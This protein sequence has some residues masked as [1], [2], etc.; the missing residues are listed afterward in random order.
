MR[1]YMILFSIFFLMNH[2]AMAQYGDFF[3]YKD[4]ETGLFQDL[5]RNAPGNFKFLPN[6]T[7]FLYKMADTIYYNSI[8]SLKYK[9]LSLQEINM[10]FNKNKID[11]LSVIGQ[12]TILDTDKFLFKTPYRYMILQTSDTAIKEYAFP[13]SAENAS[14]NQ[15]NN[16]IALTIKN[17]LAIIDENGEIN[18]ITNDTNHWITNGHVVHRY[19]FGIEEGYFW[20]PDGK[21]LAF[22]K[23]DQRKITKYPLVETDNDFATVNYIPY[24]MAGQASEIVSVWIYDVASRELTKVKTEGDPEQYYTNITWDNESQNVYIQQLNR[25]QDTMHLISY[26]AVS[27]SAVDTLFTETNKKYVEPQ[28][29]LYFL[30]KGKGDFLYQSRRDGYNHIYYYS[31]TNH[32][33]KQ[34][35]KGDWEVIDLFGVDS[36]DQFLYFRGNREG[37]KQKHIYCYDMKTSETN[38]ITKETGINNAVFSPNFD[39]LIHIYSNYETPLK[40]RLLNKQGN[41]LKEVYSAP[42]S[43]EEYAI[44]PAQYGTFKSADNKWDLNY[45]LIKPLNIEPGQ[46]YPLVFYMYGGP[47]LQLLENSWGGRTWFWQQY[48]AQHGVASFTFDCRGSSNRGFEF[49]SVIHRKNGIPQLEDVN[50]AL[51][52]VKA[53]DYVDTNRLGIHGWS[54]GGFMTVQ[55]MLKNSDDFKVGVAGGPVI[56]WAKYEVMY[57]E[58][59][60]DT[61]QENPDG[62]AETNLNNFADSLKGKLLIIHGAQDPIV[63]WQHSMQ[64]VRSC[65]KSNKQVDY[66]VYPSHEHNVRGKDRE[67]LIEK[68]TEYFL[69]NL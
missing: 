23:N 61:P 14:Y 21:K 32:K 54:F 41:L 20:S 42:N 10:F 69:E 53:L 67:H 25:G 38:V 44:S 52:F 55:L 12:F 43:L 31:R 56:D 9:K 30:K 18:Q 7:V 35:T 2:G 13:D 27:G 45:R 28:F 1:Y 57:G 34:L 39:Y 37:N 48:L 60:M 3:T 26:N 11:T 33:L 63:L 40:Y 29:P 64:F 47:H 46:K 50:E 58:R 66:F 49:E 19:E 65:V 4:I 36:T 15:T 22:Y 6:D 24:P 62:Y 68:I 5:Y 51:E 59:Y 16:L 8:H 17:N